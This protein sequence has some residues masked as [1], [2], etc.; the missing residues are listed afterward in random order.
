M[1]FLAIIDLLIWSLCIIFGVTQVIVPLWQGKPL[2]PFFRPKAKLEYKLSE[3]KEE[4]EEEIL[5]EKIE[6]LK[7]K[8]PK[9][10]KPTSEE[11]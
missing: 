9:T 2:L 4:K 5:K 3:A 8:K 10:N 7:N 6:T 1:S 11:E